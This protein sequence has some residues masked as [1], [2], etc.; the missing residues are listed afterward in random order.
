MQIK[1]EKHSL[2]IGK[3]DG[4]M[5]CGFL[6]QGLISTTMCNECVA[7]ETECNDTTLFWILL[8]LVRREPVR[9]EHDDSDRRRMHA[10]SCKCLTRTNP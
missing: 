9:A 8:D 2:Q 7:Q 10:S 5:G 4:V 3:S 6:R 1:E